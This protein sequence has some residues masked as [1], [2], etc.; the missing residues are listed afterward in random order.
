MTESTFGAAPPSGGTST[1]PLGAALGVRP[2]HAFAFTGD[3]ME[4]FAIQFVNGVL[5]MVTLGIFYPWARIRELRFLI[6][7]LRIGEDSLTFRGSGGELFGGVLRAWLFF[8]LPLFL[9]GFGFN[10]PQLDFGT[11]L[12]MI[13]AFYFLLFVFVSYALMGSLRYRASRSS[14]RGIR[15]GFDGKFGEFGSSYG[16]RM[17]LAVV[18]FGIAYPHASTWRREYVMTHTRFGDER[19][20]FDGQAS[21][22]FGAWLLCWFL[23]LPTLGLSLTW[24]HGHQQAYYWNHTT[25]A[26]GRFRSTL[27]G[28]DWLGKSLLNLLLVL[29]TFGL[30]APWA[31][32]N[33]HREFFS[34]LSLEDADLARVTAA[35]SAGSPLGEGAADVLDA[36]GGIDI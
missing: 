10:W 12:L 35:E 15:F 4:Y 7:S 30:A 8:I 33:L 25:F 11:R 28:G 23:A 17:L 13:V 3:G 36:D 1:S 32:V 31:F 6:G 9:L 16:L 27:T 20:G 29:F 18:S 2:G 26:G 21:D 19:L 14:W 22:L 5:T 24:F 34:R